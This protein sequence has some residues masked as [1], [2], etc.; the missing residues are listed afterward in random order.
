[1]NSISVAASLKD[2]ALLQTLK[3]LI[4]QGIHAMQAGD[5]ASAVHAFERAR[6]LAPDSLPAHAIATHNLLITCK[7]EIDRLLQDTAFDAATPWL[8]H[9][10]ALQPRGSL[11][12]DPG[13]RQRFA[14]TCYDLGKLFYRSRCWEAALACVRRA[15]EIRRCP[16]YY[17]DLTN[18]L[19]FTRTP[20]RLSDYMPDCTPAQLGRHLFVACTPKSGSTFLKNLLTDLTGFKD[21]F[22]VYAGLQ[23]EQDLDLPQLSQFAKLDKVTQQHCRASEAN[24]HLMQAFGIRPV[25]LVRNIYDTVMSL[26]DFYDG[27]F[28]YSTFFDREEYVAMDTSARLDLLIDFAVPWYFQFVASWQRVER[29]QRL[30]VLWLDYDTLTTDTAACLQRVLRLNGLGA[31][32]EDLD[33]VIAARNRDARGNRF[34]RGVRGRG[35]TGLS[36]EQRSRIDRLAHAFP[37]TDFRV[38]GIEPRQGTGG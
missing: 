29:K 5:A 31:A 8:Q 24:I 17:V 15:I 25:V 35:L 33:R 18:A 36:P 11:A 21:V 9:A 3:T 19:A 23:N 30:P 37:G 26:L 12:E 34:N 4:D 28:V 2:E 10:L 13:F 14:D 6:T 20:A 7:Q 1:M 32:Q 22:S 27:G 38:L 16:S